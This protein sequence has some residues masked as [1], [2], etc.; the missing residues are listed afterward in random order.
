MPATVCRTDVLNTQARSAFPRE[1]TRFRDFPISQICTAP[2]FQL[3]NKYDFRTGPQHFFL[4]Y[5]ISSTAIAESDLKKAACT[6]ST[7]PATQSHDWTMCQDHWRSRVHCGYQFN[8]SVVC[9]KYTR[10]ATQS[11][12]GT[13][14]QQDHL[15]SQLHCGKQ[16]EESFTRSKHHACHTKWRSYTPANTLKPPLHCKFED[17]AIMPAT[18]CRTDV[19]NTQAQSAIPRKFTHKVSWPSHLPNLHRATVSAI[20]RVRFPHRAT[21]FFSKLHHFQRCRCEKTI[22][23]KLHAFKAPRLPHKVTTGQCA[24]IT[25]GR[26]DIAESTFTLNCIYSQLHL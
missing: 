7:T 5:I 16:F 17:K 15:M 18:V 11:Y 9:S 12:D 25:W 20:Q 14:W 13:M 10:P 24:K 26:V 23:R 6:Q 1:F 19:L 21:A 8:E 3:S 4:S 22:W 2:K